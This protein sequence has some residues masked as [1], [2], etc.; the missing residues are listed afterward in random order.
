[1][2][3]GPSRV[4]EQSSGGFLLDRPHAVLY[5]LPPSEKRGFPP[6]YFQQRIRD[7]EVLPSGC[8][9]DICVVFQEDLRNLPT[10]TQVLKAWN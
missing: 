6:A 7:S 9:L 10:N 5:N 2:G 1:M 3:A 4:P 8:H